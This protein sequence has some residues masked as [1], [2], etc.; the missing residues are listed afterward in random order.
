MMSV[1]E[2]VTPESYWKKFLGIEMYKI[3]W[4]AKA[5]LYKLFGITLPKLADQ[6]DYWI[7]RGQVYRDEILSSGYLDREVFFQDMLTDYLKRVEFS[8]F[9]EAGCGFGWNIGRI[10]KD[11]P[12][13]RVGGLDFSLTQLGNS[14]N[15]LPDSKFQ[16]A[17]GDAC[18]MPFTDNAF[19]VG[20][21]LGVFMNIHPDKIEAALREMLRVSGKYVIHLEYDETNTTGELRKKRAPKTNIV[22]HDYKALYESYGCEVLEFTTYKDFGEGYLA[23]ARAVSTDLD[24]WEGFEGAE[25]YIFIVV[26]AS[27]YQPERG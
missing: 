10:R 4:Y 11:F 18:N 5:W 7:D 27:N 26:D 24:R 19:D 14:K 6:R 23:H 22:G 16:L 2:N 12:E 1:N 17:N 8:S 9:F 3:E 15:Y 25:K 20:F 13:T 21:S